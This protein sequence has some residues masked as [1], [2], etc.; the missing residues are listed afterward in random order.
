MWFL[1]VRGV[2]YKVPC[3]DCEAMYVGE[4]LCT[5]PTRLQEHQRHTWKGELRSAIAEHACSLQHQSCWSDAEVIEHELD[6]R[7]GKMKEALHICLEKSKGPVM[8]KDHGWKVNEVWRA[9][10]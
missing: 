8:N 5:L 2:V 1:P 3:Q 9:L 4:T 10:L 7:S 6:L